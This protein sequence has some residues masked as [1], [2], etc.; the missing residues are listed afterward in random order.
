MHVPVP[1]AVSLSALAA[2][3]GQAFNVSAVPSTLYVAEA[4]WYRTS[5]SRALRRPAGSTST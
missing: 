1:E 4:I 5:C 2:R 3:T